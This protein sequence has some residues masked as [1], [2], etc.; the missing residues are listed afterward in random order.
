[1]VLAGD[2]YTLVVNGVC[3]HFQSYESIYMRKY[4]AHANIDYI[5]TFFEEIMYGK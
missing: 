2:M 4:A 1:M 5:I 3:Q